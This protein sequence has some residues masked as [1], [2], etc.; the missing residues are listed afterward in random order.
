MGFDNLNPK[1]FGASLLYN[2]ECWS[3]GLRADIIQSTVNA[4]NGQYRKN[5][6]KFYVLFS[7]RGL[8]DTNINAYSIIQENPL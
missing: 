4:I 7:L 3:L 8:G 1:S 2:A 5:E 6:I